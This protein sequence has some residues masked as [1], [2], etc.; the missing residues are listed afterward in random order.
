[1]WYSEYV[2]LMFIK[3]LSSSQYSKKQ[4]DVLTP[5]FL[6]LRTEEPDTNH[7]ERYHNF[8][9]KVLHTGLWLWVTMSTINH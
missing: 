2:L 8:Q 4:E 1:M 6:I 9:D 7:S 3:Y 5:C